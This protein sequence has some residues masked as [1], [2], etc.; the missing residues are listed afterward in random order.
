MEL[1]NCRMAY[2]PPLHPAVR[3]LL[4]YLLGGHA[5]SFS[6]TPPTT[7]PMIG[8]SA[9][10]RRGTNPPRLLLLYWRS[11]LLNFNAIVDPGFALSIFEICSGR[12]W[13][14]P[15]AV[16]IWFAF[17]S[18]KLFYPRSQRFR[19]LYRSLSHIRSRSSVQKSTDFPDSK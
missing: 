13:S 6:T 18:K 14:R 15:R 1:L 7:P 16:D 4:L 12:R 9:A 11:S 17:S 8:A 2:R 19:R 5:I 3:S 10:S